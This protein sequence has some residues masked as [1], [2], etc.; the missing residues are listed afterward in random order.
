M[1]EEKRIS[2]KQYTRATIGGIIHVLDR[3]FLKDPALFVDEMIKSWKASRGVLLDRDQREIARG[4][5]LNRC[6]T[7][8]DGVTTNWIVLLDEKSGYEIFPGSEDTF[9]KLS[10]QRL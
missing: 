2:L 8:E 10:I 6:H 9:Q 5:I 3:L 7:W 1:E 4:L